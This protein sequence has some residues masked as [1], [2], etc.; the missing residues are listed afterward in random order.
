M[1]F[2]RRF[3]Y[4]CYLSFVEQ[5]R[6][7][8]AGIL[9]SFGANPNIPD[10]FGWT[11]VHTCAWND[12]IPLL[13]MCVRKGGKVNIANKQ[14]QL[15]VDLASI[16]GNSEVVEYLEHQSCDIK[17]MC[18]VV[19][20]DTMGKR[21]HRVKELP[22]P[23]SLRLFVNYGSPY[24]GWKATLIPESPW[25]TEQLH[26]ETDLN[27]DEL[28]RFIQENASNDFLEDNSEKMSEISDLVDMF[29]SMYIWEAF[30]KNVDYEEPEARKPRYSMEKVDKTTEAINPG[31]YSQFQQ[32]LKDMGLAT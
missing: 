13:K 15:P 2:K 20:R 25:T 5:R 7:H 31:R 4:Q 6:L 26:N 18:R 17:A 30:K 10:K 27:K 19:I 21:V 24:D 3:C 1:Y 23:P 29:Q 14:K 22:L 12:D 28:K 16:R 32:W 9:L 11:M 8:T